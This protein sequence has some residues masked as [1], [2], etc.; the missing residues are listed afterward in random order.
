MRHRSSFWLAAGLVLAGLSGAARAQGPGPWAD[1]FEAYAVGSTMPGQGGWEEWDM[2]IHVNPG[3]VASTPV[4]AQH[5]TKYMMVKNDA[6]TIRQFTG[7]TSGQYRLTG[8]MYLPGTLARPAYWLVLNTYN[9][10][11]PYNWSVQIRFN[12]PNN[13]GGWIIDAGSVGT[14]SGTYVKDKWFEIRMDIDLTNDVAEVYMDNVLIAPAY[15]W[16]NGVFGGGGGVL[17]IACLDDYAGGTSVPTDENY[18]DNHAVLPIGGGPTTYCTAKTTSNGCVP[19]I[20]FAGSPS[21]S[22]GSGFL[23]TA[24]QV[25]PNKF[26][27][28]FYS[29]SGQQ[30]VAFQ[31]GFLCAKPPLVRTPLQSSGGLAAC[32][33]NYSMDFNAFIASGKDPALVAGVTVDGQYWFRD[34]GFAPPNNTGLTNAI[35]FTIN[36]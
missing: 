23:I 36:P 12:E 15:S 16:Q 29:K 7:Y 19:A 24:S 20:G 27:L 10:F 33:G 11:G 25:E 30:A 3:T 22:A 4:A 8:W 35:D 28:F 2:A 5:G 26:G 31:G 17:S 14:N 13:P 6:D 18:F 34:P 1:S 32:S 21:A 9:H